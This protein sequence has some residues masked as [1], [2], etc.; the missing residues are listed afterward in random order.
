MIVALVANDASQE[1]CEICRWNVWRTYEE[2]YILSQKLQSKYPDS[3]I[4]ALM[5]YVELLTKSRNGLHSIEF[6]RPQSSD[7]PNHDSSSRSNNKFLEI[8]KV[9]NIYIYILS[10][11]SSLMI[12]VQLYL[13]NWLESVCQ[14]AQVDND[15]I[16]NEFLNIS[17][18]P[19]VVTSMKSPDLESYLHENYF[20]PSTY[21]DDVTNF[22]DRKLQ[23]SKSHHQLPLSGTL[24]PLL[25]SKYGL[26][27]VGSSIKN[28]NFLDQ[29]DKVKNMSKDCGLTHS[30]KLR[31][32]NYIHD[33]VKIAAG[34]PIAKF[35]TMEFY[36]VN[37]K[38]YGDRHDH[39]SRI[40]KVK[41]RIEILSQLEE[42]PFVFLVNI[43]LPGDPPLSIVFY[44]VIPSY[45]HENVDHSPELQK[46]RKLYE[47]LIDLPISET[48][49]LDSSLDNLSS[50]TA[51][52]SKS[53]TR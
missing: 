17:D 45:F 28:F 7:N 47:K 3:D 27:W 41:E 22:K 2:F 5:S 37:V 33:K 14:S 18:L 15:N 49:S 6:F 1:L 20:N 9:C 52:S 34:P 23:N 35:V 30:F 26:K 36:E 31:G 8:V 44:F 42:Q 40:G 48:S 21:E 38:K 39:I 46:V 43:Q 16:F 32:A 11:E 50:E 13:L 25:N 51:N 53:W 4:P 10:C 24:S 19:V 12:Y 29:S